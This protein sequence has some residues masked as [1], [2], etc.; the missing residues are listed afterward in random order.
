MNNSFK[1]LLE[2]TPWVVKMTL[3]RRLK[4]LFTGVN[5]KEVK[6]TLLKCLF[7]GFKH[8]CLVLCC[9]SGATCAI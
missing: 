8:I 5:P 3:L 6:M 1:S 9:F 2:I 4:T 7:C